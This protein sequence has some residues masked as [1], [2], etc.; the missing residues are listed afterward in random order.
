MLGDAFVVISPDTRNF[1]ASADRQIKQALA[2]LKYTVPLGVDASGTMAAMRLLQQ[3]MRQLGLADFLD[4]NIPVGKLVAQVQLIKRLLNQAHIAD[5]LEV[6]LDQAALARQLA[7]LRKAA[8]S[9]TAEVP[10]TF[11]VSN[12]PVLGPIMP[13]TEKIKT[14]WDILPLKPLADAAARGV[15]E[16]IPVTFD[17]GPLP[18]LGTIISPGT[19]KV[20]LSGAVATTAALAAAM[21]AENSAAADLGRTVRSLNG[22][23]AALAGADQ[24]LAAGTALQTDM[25]AKEAA[26]VAL[27]ATAFRALEPEV[28]ALAGTGG[29]GIA[30]LAAGLAA[31]SASFGAG[32]MW[33]GRWGGALTA[34]IP[35]IGTTVRSMAGWHIILDLVIEGLIAVGLAAAAA[36]AGI[37][38]A[39]PAAHNLFDWLQS[40]HTV[41]TALGQV[42]SPMTGQFQA[43]AKAMAPQ[44]IEAYG[45]ALNA[46]TGKTG[47]LAQVAARVV[48]LFDDW[49]A[50]IDLW[51]QSQGGFTK[52]LQ[53][54]IG[55][56]SQFAGIVANVVKAIAMLLTKDPGIARFLLDF[57]AGVSKLLVAFASLPG[58]IVTAVL[59]LHGLY[60]WSSVLL[61]VVLRLGQY[62]LTLGGYMLMLATNPFFWVAVAAAGIA[63]LA[64]E[65]TQ[66]SKS[67]KDFVSALDA[68]LA[69]DTATQAIVQ[70]A[71]DVGQLTVQI[72]AA[73]AAGVAFAQVSF[74]AQLTDAAKQAKAGNLLGFFTDLARGLADVT[75]GMMGFSNGSVAAGVA[76]AQQ[77]N[78][79]KLYE[80]KI[81][82]LIAEQ[83]VLFLVAGQLVSG[84]NT[85]T[86]STYSL[87]QAF[88]IEDLAGVKAGDSLAL[89]TQKVAN[90]LRGYEAMSIQ[91]TLLANSVSAVTFATLQQDS[92]VTQLTGAWTTFI[93]M[94]TGG[95]SAFVTFQQQISTISSDLSGIAPA[96]IKGATSLGGLSAASLQA[97]GAFVQGVTNA[98]ALVNAL[99]LQASASGLAGRGTDLLTA[100]VKD[101]V[102]QLLPMAGSSKAAQASLIAL[103]QQGGAP[104]G[105]SFQALSKWVGTASGTMGKA[106]AAGGPAA[107]LNAI[108]GILAK[109]SE[110][111]TTDVEKLSVA[112]GTNLTQAESQ[113]ILLA[114]GGVKPFQ[115]F[116]NAIVNTGV[117]S[118]TTRKAAIKLGDE[119]LALSNNN[120]PAA[121]AEFES[122]AI[123]GL[124]LTKKQA[125]LLWQTIVQNGIPAL[126]GLG[127]TAD[128]L[129]QNHLAP[130]GAGVDTVAGKVA[131][132]SR[133]L[134]AVPK[135]VNTQITAH[136][137]G[138]GSIAASENIPGFTGT[139][140]AV[141]AFHAAGGKITGG[142]P[143]RDSVLGM[144]MPGEVVVP[145]NMVQAGAVDHL[146]GKLPGF[147]S[148]GQVTG[149]IGNPAAP[150]QFMAKTSSDFAKNAEIKFMQDALKKFKADVAA[151][152]GSGP[153]I[154]KYARSFLGQIPYV[155]GGDSLSRAGADCSGFTSAVYG[156]FGILAPRTSEAQFGWAKK[157]GAVPGGLAFYVS[158]AGGPPPGHVAIVQDAGSVI[159]QGGGM[160]PT[161]ENLHF[162]PLMGTGVPPGGF[163]SAAGGGGNGPIAGGSLQAIAQQLLNQRGWGSQ[164]PSFNA[165]ENREAGWNM[166]AQNPSSGAYGLAQFINGPSEYYQ[167]GGNPNTGVGQLTAMMNY[168]AQRYGDP[169]NAWDHESLF[170]WYGKGGQ[171]PGYAAGGTA[172]PTGKQLKFWLGA[173]QYGELLKYHGLQASFA[174]GPAKYR[175]KAVESELG[176]LYYRQL[177]E[178]AAYKGAVSGTMTK[179][180]V[181]H[182]GAAARSEYSVAQ[183]QALS[184]MPGGH[185]L[186]AK[187][188]RTYLAQISRLAGVLIPG[189][190]VGSGGGSGGSGGKGGPPLPDITH[191][192]G[193]V[194]DVIER[195][196]QA[197]AAPLG[198]AR[199]GLVPQSFDRGGYLRPGMNLAWN[200][201]GRP[202]RVGDAGNVTVEAHLHV[203]G[204][205]GSATELE[206][207][208]VKSVNKAARLGRL[209][210]A[211]VKSV[212]GQ[213]THPGGGFGC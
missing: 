132:L 73:R 142:T 39:A 129:H 80:D 183:D 13:L 193:A 41:S 35:I 164:W 49:I 162:L 124:G 25:F 5:A 189:S 212:S 166:T 30:G 179:A 209:K 205:V 170:G 123:G 89:A 171:I 47:G 200:G 65:M 68:A 18:S 190:G 151:S 121:K 118:D 9:V 62:L 38:A 59:A 165:L 29:G 61:P 197:H 111:L 74:T 1:R 67:A 149:S 75:G 17:V 131:N 69:N 112:L 63:Y 91:G 135:N 27:N 86:K 94:V 36:A 104:A 172:L 15:H 101:T 66:A 106:G 202:E 168:I 6:N 154:V 77:G 31:A 128:N 4:V 105:I 133:Y 187:D 32:A 144:L 145:T 79:V 44:V 157:S 207:W 10:V 185:P 201:T 169:V 138:T 100:A 45:G 95:L 159:S 167:Y 55:Y 33:T 148:G 85:L 51:A 203:H 92:K 180:G 161:I 143:G 126:R 8:N 192:Y 54:G 81:R 109:S 93:S 42:I 34:T 60:L 137:S 43:L 58:P 90:L 98:N 107:Q 24:V 196:L 153:E 140:A 7:V 99:T 213:H 76:M 20:D 87:A 52:L 114:K 64:Y 210:Y 108:V 16:T 26:A 195:F 122:F 150:E 136:A 206:A 119:F 48:T 40:V 96:A 97:S 160:G 139:P 21:R 46:L 134:L 72:Q 199:G 182:L 181:A 56:L 2:G 146:R 57:I 178:A 176:T 12:L 113:A 110:N 174:H 163:P 188:L 158:P 120:V 23:F 194:T 130:L 116:A 37:A 127:S 177:A 211:L 19:G 103:A 204:P 102:A 83:G 88:A 11:D 198:A 191:T 84:N 208:L 82:S 50:K 117:G 115:D 3:R 78:S 155:W 186:F 53:S 125:D 22:I 28:A 70:I 152:F 173:A 14:G 71:A 175:T 156:H 184:K 147:A 141:L